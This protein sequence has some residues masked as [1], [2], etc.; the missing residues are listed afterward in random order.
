M[1]PGELEATAEIGDA[2]SMT[3]SPDGRFYAVLA[4]VSVVVLDAWDR[5]YPECAVLRTDPAARNHWIA[6]PRADRICFGTFYGSVRVAA[7][8]NGRFGGVV[9]RRR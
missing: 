8:E 3:A 1:F 2:V 6:W 7:F 4:A 5:G 9:A